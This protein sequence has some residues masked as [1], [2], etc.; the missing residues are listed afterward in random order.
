LSPPSPPDVNEE[1]EDDGQ[2]GEIDAGDGGDLI[3]VKAKAIARRCLELV[4]EEMG[5]MRFK[6]ES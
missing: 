4:G 5:V 3:E 6:S 2:N 1:T